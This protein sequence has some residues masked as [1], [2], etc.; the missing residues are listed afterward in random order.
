MNFGASLL[1]PIEQD[2]RTHNR[3]L[4]EN[5]CASLART[6]RGAPFSG[7]DLNFCQETSRIT[8]KAASEGALPPRRQQARKWQQSATG[9]AGP[10][11]SDGTWIARNLACDVPIE[12]ENR[13]ARIA[14]KIERRLAGGPYRCRFHKTTVWQCWHN[15]SRQHDARNEAGTGIFQPKLAVMQMADRG[16][17]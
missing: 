3:R 7:I 2:Q 14:K 17:D 6:K 12:R 5:V 8:S 1:T 10:P 16:D 11:A 15:H 13:V 9:S 4:S